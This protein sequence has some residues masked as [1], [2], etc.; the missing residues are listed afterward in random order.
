MTAMNAGEQDYKPLTAAQ[1]AFFTTRIEQE[2]LAEGK[3]LSEAERL[4]L[5]EDE[6]EGIP[7]LDRLWKDSTVSEPFERRATALLEKALRRDRDSN[8]NTAF[9]FRAAL[10]SL[11]ETDSGILWLVA[12]G[13]TDEARRARL[14]LRFLQL[15][16][17][18]FALYWGYR[19]YCWL[20]R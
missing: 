15:A 20:Q 16:S 14:K 18:P 13:A 7:E 9:E 5:M 6:R 3:P 12:E 1:A 10:D 8:P 2:A 17:L 4:Y 11:K 19:F